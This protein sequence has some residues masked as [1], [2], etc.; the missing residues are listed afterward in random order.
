MKRYRGLAVLGLLTALCAGT[1]WLT[2]GVTARYPAWGEPVSYPVNRVAG[3]ELSIE[4]PTW[5]PY[6]GYTLRYEIQIDSEEIYYLVEDGSPFAYL[7]G[8]ADGQ[9]YRLD[10][11]R[12]Q[13]G[14]TTFDLGGNGNT[15]FYGSVVQKYDGYGTRLEPGTY[16]LTMELTDRQG[17][18]HYLAAEFDVA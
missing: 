7:E 10:C 11:Q 4:E 5:S 12:E 13:D 16:R 8:L 6:R 14:C 2:V 1:V 17:A 3:Y 15:A 9:W 18:P